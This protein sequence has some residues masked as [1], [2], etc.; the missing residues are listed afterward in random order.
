MPFLT[1]IRSCSRFPMHF[2]LTCRRLQSLSNINH[3]I[4]PFC[5]HHDGTP[6]RQGFC[7]ELVARWALGRLL[8]SKNTTFS[9]KKGHFEQSGPEN[10]PPRGPTGTYKK[11]E[12][13]QSYLWTWGR[14]DPIESGLSG[15]KKMSYVGVAQK[16][17]DFWTKN[18]VFWSENLLFDR[19][20]RFSSVDRLQPS[21]LQSFWRLRNNFSTFRFRVRAFFV[22]F[23]TP[24]QLIFERL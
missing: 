13:I 14:Y 5:Y 6:Y 24:P 9:P 3:Y 12:G 22:D 19:G 1:N 2:L 17:T 20:P 7:V 16:K 10:G 15:A 8:G 18:A 21:S 11:T 23:G 4:F